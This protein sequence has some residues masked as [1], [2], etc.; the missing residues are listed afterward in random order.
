M[1]VGVQVFIPK[2]ESGIFNKPIKFNR[3]PL[4]AAIEQ[5]SFSPVLPHS[6]PFLTL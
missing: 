5:I 3:I 6:A 4:S 1:K 2:L